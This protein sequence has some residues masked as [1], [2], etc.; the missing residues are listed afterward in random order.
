VIVRLERDVHRRAGHVFAGLTRRTQGLRLSV[1]LTFA[2]M[3]TFAERSPAANDDRADRR[4]RCRFRNRARGQFDGPREI[5]R[6]RSV[7]GV[8]ST[9]FQ[10]AM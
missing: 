4:V 5:G 7:Y 6:V 2:V 9:P 10:N 8:T 1:G 3:P